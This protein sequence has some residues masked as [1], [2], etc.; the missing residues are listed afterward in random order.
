MLGKRY[1]WE[2]QGESLDWTLEKQV[3]TLVGWRCKGPAAVLG[4]GGSQEVGWSEGRD[5]QTMLGY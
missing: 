3:R 2:G 5:G 1:G 4:P